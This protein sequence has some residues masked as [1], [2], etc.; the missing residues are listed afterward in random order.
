MS[1]NDPR[2]RIM[3]RLTVNGK[4]ASV[5]LVTLLLVGLLLIACQPVV[6]SNSTLEAS[7]T[8]ST[9][10][11]PTS[12]P[13]TATLAPK[14]TA[15]SAPSPSAPRETEDLV[16]D[17][18]ELATSLPPTPSPIAV[19][20]TEPAGGPDVGAET[21]YDLRPIEEV[22]ASGPPQI[23]DITAT[24]AVLLFESSV[25]LACSVVY[26]TTTAYGQI[27]VDQD[28]NGGAHTDHHPLLLELEPDTEYHYRVQ[29]SAPDG[30]LYISNDT[31]FRTLPA[32]E[33][34]EINL[35]SVDE[36]ARII[37][38]SS[39]FGGAANDETW[40]ADGAIDGNRGTAW[41]SSGDGNEAFVEI[42]L[43]QPAKVY[44]VEV[45]TRSM[46][47][48]TAQI[49]DFTLT[50]DTGEV[51]GPFTLKDAAQAYRFEV[52]FVARSIR[53]DV[54]DSSGGNTGLIEL[55]VYG[56]PIAN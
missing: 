3:K 6:T 13:S 56:T 9:V 20:P 28:M 24:D 42:E 29:G 21:T 41:S 19:P 44:A 48:G 4:T 50:T 39:N 53:L 30:T 51:L 37:A 40:G 18:V 34:T 25:P 5:M 52:D 16:T 11:P 22:S 32:E 15:T 17:T 49:F 54:V 45:W 27:A 10:V 47:D 38:V 43:A 33:K 23:I 7:S 26:G 2:G 55:A 14:S 35:A 36:G 31:T 8:V 46:S 1:K 12:V